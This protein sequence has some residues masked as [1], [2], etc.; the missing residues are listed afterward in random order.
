MC[1]GSKTSWNLVRPTKGNMLPSHNNED[2][3]WDIGAN[4]DIYPLQWWVPPNICKTLLVHVL[5]E[6]GCSIDHQ[7]DHCWALEDG[8]KGDLPH[9]GCSYWQ[10][11]NNL[12][13]WLSYGESWP[14]F[15]SAWQTG[16]ILEVILQGAGPDSCILPWK[17]SVLLQNSCKDFSVNSH[18]TVLLSWGDSN[19]LWT[20]DSEF[21]IA[22]NALPR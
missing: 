4:I 13:K 11:E 12:Q 1:T 18:V 22:S 21:R 14:V 19:T 7:R 10:E 20:L 15:Q 5:V 16:C 6:R 17:S 2:L 9:E 8:N 3:N